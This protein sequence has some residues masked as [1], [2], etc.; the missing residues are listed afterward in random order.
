MKKLP[1]SHLACFLTLATMPVL[2]QALPC[3]TGPYAGLSFGAGQGNADISLNTNTNTTIISEDV[4]TTTTDITTEVTSGKLSGKS[5]GSL[6]D[7]LVGYNFNPAKY[8]YLVF[9]GQLEGTFFSNIN[10]NAHGQRYGTGIETVNDGVVS[11]TST[12]NVNGDYALSNELQSMVTLLLR[13]GYLLQPSTLIYLLAGGVEGNF[14]A[15]ANSDF[16]GQQRNKWVLGYTLGAGLE[17]RLDD[18]WSIRG[19]YR[20]I[21]FNFNRN[22]SNSAFI[23]EDPEGPN[24]LVTTNITSSGHVNTHFNFNMGMVAVVYQFS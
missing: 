11:S 3:W 8:P 1:L 7:L 17:Y 13:G 24:N 15:P 21:Q 16:L 22:N 20:Y 2:T 6:A 18:N 12:T 23:S 5:N 14:V 19:E 9:S 4:G 10:Q